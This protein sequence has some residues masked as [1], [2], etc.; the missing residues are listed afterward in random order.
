M[1]ALVRA[2]KEYGAW[3]AEDRMT[4]SGM[5][6]VRLRLAEAR[7]N[8]AELE[9]ITPAELAAEMRCEWCGNRS[10]RRDCETC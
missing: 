9:G 6:W 1:N 5:P 10:D 2:R 3:V 7:E 4:R 8:L